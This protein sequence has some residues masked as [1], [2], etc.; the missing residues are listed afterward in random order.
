ML[1]ARVR[2][3]LS[4]SQVFF[5]E[6]T[7]A[8]CGKWIARYAWWQ[9]LFCTCVPFSRKPRSLSSALELYPANEFK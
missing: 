6:V 5:I 1:S 3:P 7:Y 9:T 8:T 2:I 4:A